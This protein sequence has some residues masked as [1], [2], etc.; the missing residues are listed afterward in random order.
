MGATVS[1]ARAAAWLTRH[2]IRWVQVHPRGLRYSATAAAILV[3]V[4]GYYVFVRQADRELGKSLDCLA[5]NIYHEARGEPVEA[6]VAIANV[7]VNRI[8]H[9][10]FPNNVCDV[11]KQGGELPRDKC[12]FSWWCDGRSDQPVDLRTLSRLRGLAREV[13]RGKYDDPTNGSLWY[14]AKGVTPEWRRDF[15]QG[16]TIGDHIFY[17]PRV[18]AK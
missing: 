16:P 6:Q 2:A 10:R 15:V 11:I 1:V 5:L 13:L 18:P 14:H 9:P 4:A 8:A 3:L 7:V 12:Q 17:I